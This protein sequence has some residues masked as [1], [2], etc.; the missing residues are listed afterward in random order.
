[1]KKKLLILGLI[2][3]MAFTG[4]GKN[5]EEYKEKIYTPVKENV[6]KL[7]DIM[8]DYLTRTEEMRKGNDNTEET[9]LKGF[10]EELEAI[11]KDMS[12]IKPIDSFKD[13]EKK[14]FEE[15]LSEFKNGAES[16]NE[17][18]GD[19]I[20]LYVLG[21]TDKRIEEYEEKSKAANDSL[22]KFSKKFNELN[23]KFDIKEEIKIENRTTEYKEKEITKVP[24]TAK[25]ELLMG[26]YLEG[27]NESKDK[28][29]SAEFDKENRTFYVVF[30]D[31]L[32]ITDAEIIRKT[33]RTTSSTISNQIAKEV[34]VKIV[35]D[36]KRDEP[37]LTALDGLIIEDNI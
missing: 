34:T 7:N 35:Y 3:M 37:L 26:A 27:M 24:L 5:T 4:C 25:E 12:K 22:D 31:D 21:G 29:I 10:F 9:T 30:R 14:E 33:T 17:T 2:M 1:M 6:E 16:I 23:K 11:E 32:N 18:A 8:G 19:L 28:G 13:E 36:G 20:S 15:I